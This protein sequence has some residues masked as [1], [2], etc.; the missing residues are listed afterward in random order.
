M[1][2]GRRSKERERQEQTLRQG[3]Q[4]Q[5]QGQEQQQPS[6]AVAVWLSQTPNGIK[7][8][9]VNGTT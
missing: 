6:Q 8:P 4:G 9:F 2:M 1:Q 7:K 5:E 3:S